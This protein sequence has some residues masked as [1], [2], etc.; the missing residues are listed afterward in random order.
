MAKRVRNAKLES[1]TAREKLP[2]RGK[3]VYVP[4]GK[5]LHLGYRKGKSEGRWVVRLYEAEGRTY[6][7]E[8]IG[9]ADDAHDA[10]GT[11]YLD[12]WQAQARAREKLAA[13][14][15]G[16]R[17]GPYLVREAC[18]D[19]LADYLRRSG[20]DE[21]N[22]RSRLDRIK[23][24]LGSIEVA[25][26]TVRD[27]RNWHSA[28][29]AGPRLTRSKA[30]DEATGERKGRPIDAADADAV[31]RRKASANR[32]LNVAKAALN[33]A[34]H[35]PPEGV[36]IAS[37]RAWESV[38]P[39]REA[40]APKIRFLTDAEQVRLL[41]ACPPD[42]RALVAAA[43]LTGARYSELCRLRV[44]DFDEDAK[45]LRIELSKSGKPRSIALT[46]E[47]AAHFAELAKGKKGEALLLTRLDGEPWQ[48]SHQ[49]RRMADACTNAKIIPSV[50]F[51]ILRH[52]YAARLASRRAPMAV[53]A[54]QLGHSDTRMTERHYA[55]LAPSFVSDTVRA[56]FGDIGLAAPPSNVKALKPKRPSR[57]RAA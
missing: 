7:V 16:E 10:D 45:A 20:K 52:S 2:V 18:D 32:L 37:R 8:T 43:L 11:R 34:F 47:G 36:V 39:Y 54:A 53:I 24:A 40:D 14:H 5:G 6:V 27:V 29:A 21:T 25:K 56:L 57:Q 38:K 19:Y 28:L 30:L 4:I 15:A 44:R 13:S 35:H 9:T 3:P 17:S 23:T 26:L 55:H 42:F 49:L 51:H 22:A 41:N 31:R 1:R 50:S 12:F 48:S 46:D 33:H